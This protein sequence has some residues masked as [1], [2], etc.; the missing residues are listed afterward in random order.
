VVAWAAVLVAAWAV[1][2]FRSDFFLF[3]G[4]VPIIPRH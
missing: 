4:E 2:A 1:G 3:C